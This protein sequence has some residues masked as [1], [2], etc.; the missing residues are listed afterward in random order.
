MCLVAAYQGAGG[1]NPYDTS[2][3]AAAAFGGA[4]GMPGVIPQSYVLLVDYNLNK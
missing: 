4:A 1:Y 3:F 2:S